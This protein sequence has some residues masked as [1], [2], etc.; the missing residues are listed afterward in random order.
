[1]NHLEMLVAWAQKKLGILSPSSYPFK[2]RYDRQR[3]L[4]GKCDGKSEELYRIGEEINRG[5]RDGIGN[6]DIVKWERF[7]RGLS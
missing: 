1:M 5:F 4:N 3:Y 2:Y 7:L 6:P